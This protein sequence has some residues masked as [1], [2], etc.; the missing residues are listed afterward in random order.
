M[1]SMSARMCAPPPPP[2]GDFPSLF[3]PLFPPFP[4]V[5]FP[6]FLGG[7]YFLR[8]CLIGEGGVRKWNA[9]ES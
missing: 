2:G 5:I 7:V 8:L 6:C 3:H 4:V 9:W 1:R